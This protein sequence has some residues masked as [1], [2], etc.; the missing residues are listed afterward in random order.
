[1][2]N[3]YTLPCMKFKDANISGYEQLGQRNVFMH[4]FKTVVSVKDLSC[5]AD[6]EAGLLE[7]KCK[8]GAV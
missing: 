3:L 8:V 4:V 1:M 7:A 6:I 2:K 5:E